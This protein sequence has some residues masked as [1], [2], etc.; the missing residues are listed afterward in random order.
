MDEVYEIICCGDKLVINNGGKIETY[1]IQGHIITVNDHKK[2]PI[3]FYKDRYF[4]FTWLV[5]IGMPILNIV[6]ETIFNAESNAYS[7]LSGL[8]AGTMVSYFFYKSAQLCR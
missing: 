5:L 7:Y 8:I 3:P 6:C 1:K 4:Y 2:K